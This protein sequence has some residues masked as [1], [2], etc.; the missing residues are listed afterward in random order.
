MFAP[1]RFGYTSFQVVRRGGATVGG[2]CGHCNVPKFKCGPFLPPRY[3]DTCKR[4]PRC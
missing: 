3:R 2:A 1:A 4:N